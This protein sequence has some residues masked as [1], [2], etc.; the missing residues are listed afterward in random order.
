MY[1]LLRSLS[2][3]ALVRDQLPVFLI[4]FIIASVFYKFGKFFLFGFKL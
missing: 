4:S 3:Q 2:T 1:Q